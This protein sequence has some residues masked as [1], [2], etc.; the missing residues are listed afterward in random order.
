MLIGGLLFG[1]IAKTS[2]GVA[3][4]ATLKMREARDKNLQNDYN[5]ALQQYE[6]ADKRI[7]EHNKNLLDEMTQ[8]LQL[9]STDKAAALSKAKMIEGQIEDGVIKSKLRAGNWKSVID[10]M[11]KVVTEDEK[12]KAEKEKLEYQRQTQLLVAQEKERG[13]SAREAAKPKGILK[14]SAKILEGYIANNILSLD[15]KGLEQDLQDPELAKQIVDNR[16]EAFATEEMGKLVAQALQP[17]LPEKLRRFLTKVRDI[18]NNYYLDISGKAVTGGE[19]MRNYGTVPTPGDAPD[20]IRDKIAG[21]S[22]RLDKK[23]NVTRNLYQL[24]DVSDLGVA[25]GQKTDLVPGQNYEKDITET[26][27]S[28][29]TEEEYARVPSGAIFID[30]D[31]GKKYRKP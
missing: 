16:L 18:R 29:K 13:I 5:I 2:A 4:D 20:V 6:Q 7:R 19:A 23:I 31:D 22:G 8:A 14:P 21:M 3:L 25:A 9:L 11:Q 27:Y 26:V 17:E 12:R 1:G 10:D 30:P 24:P 28:P 15:L